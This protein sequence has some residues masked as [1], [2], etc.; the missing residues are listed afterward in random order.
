MVS[1]TWTSTRFT[2][3]RPLSHSHPVV[4]RTRATAASTACARG[5]REIVRPRNRMGIWKVRTF[6]R[7]RC[8]E[9]GEGPAGRHAGEASL[10]LSIILQYRPAW[11]VTT[12]DPVTNRGGPASG[13]DR[14]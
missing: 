12:R 11:F 7:A 2:S 13:A 8:P 1:G 10:K 5:W 3:G 4:E 14:E 6:P 9:L